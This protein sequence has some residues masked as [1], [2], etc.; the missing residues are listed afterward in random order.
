MRTS[1]VLIIAPN[2][3]AASL[4]LVLT[5]LP[6]SFYAAVVVQCPP[7][8]QGEAQ[9]G[10][11]AALPLV[12]LGEAALELQDGHI[13][14]VDQ[15]AEIRIVG[16]RVQLARANGVHSRLIVAAAQHFGESLAILVLADAQADPLELDAA[17]DAGAVVIHEFAAGV[18]DVLPI[19]DR[20]VVVPPER[21]AAAIDEVLVHHREPDGERQVRRLLSDVLVNAGIDFRLYKPATIL[22]RLARLMATDGFSDIEAYL[23][24][25]RAR[26][27]GYARL[28][29]S[30]LINVTEFFR[31]LPLYEYLRDDVLPDLIRHAEASGNELRLWSAGCATG[32]EAY[33]LAII[34]AEVLGERLG[35]FHVRIFATDVDEA[36]ITIARHGIYAAPS[37]EGMPDSLRDRYFTRVEGGFEVKKLIRNLTV[38]GQHDLAQRAPFPRIDLCLCRNVLIYFN[39]ELQQRTLQLFAFSLR[40]DG[41]LVLGKAESTS[42]LPEYFKPLHRVYKVYQRHGP[43]VLIPPSR[44]REGPPVARE[45]IAGAFVRDPDASVRPPATGSVT[46][47]ISA[48]RRAGVGFAAGDTVERPTSNEKMAAL[49]M[50][51]SVGLVIVDRR[52]DILTINP[53][54]RAFLNVHGVGVGEDLIHAASGLASGALRTMIDATFAGEVPDTGLE[55]EAID[56]L[57]D[58]SRSVLVSTHPQRDENE[59]VVSV[60]I[61]MADVSLER[62]RRRAVEEELRISRDAQREL[63]IKNERLVLRQR[64]LSS[65]NEEL[66]AANSELR[67]TNEHLLI[68]AEEAASAAEEIETLNEEMQ[69][70]NEELETLNEELQA[71]VEELNTTN[72]ELEARSAEY[73]DLAASR[74]QQ[75]LTSTRERQRLLAAFEEVSEAIAIFDDEGGIVFANAAMRALAPDGRPRVGSRELFTRVPRD[76]NADE[77]LAITLADGGNQDMLVRVRPFGSDGNSGTVVSLVPPTR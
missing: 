28:A 17:R 15:Q 14:F 76:R 60:A 43:R 55:Y 57:A 13:V 34:I 41:Y 33:S 67:Q 56:S 51:S 4:P 38:F 20:D 45:R 27:E 59:R 23:A 66:G 74:E 77:I 8:L 50:G 53:A 70:T 63:E 30:L 64:S 25:L 22:R 6:A 54:A 37:F 73:Q 2:V 10:A 18:G 62:S 42:P 21:L 65:A 46:A 32:E 26:P 44:I 12:H 61:V 31:D 72:D 48:S 3:R 9:L 39:K 58:I 68:A 11:A 7:D 71:T 47:I 40:D 16:D 75:R 52:Y 35:D 69:A 19:R 5:S 49:I 29:K 1:A 36:A 24:H